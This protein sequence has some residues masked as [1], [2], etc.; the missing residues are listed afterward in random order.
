MLTRS[1]VVDDAP[2]LIQRR[3]SDFEK[4]YV[5]LKKQ[6]PHI[7]DQVA[8]PRKHFRGNFTPET[9]ARRSRSFEQI[10]GHLYLIDTIRFCNLFKEFF[11]A[12]DLKD[13]YGHL[14]E[15][16]YF[17][18]VSLFLKVIPAQ[19]RIMG[20]YSEDVGATLCSVTV[21]YRKL[22]EK[23]LALRYGLSGLKCLKN[24]KNI[25][26]YISLLS[27]CVHLS[28]V[29]GREKQTLETKLFEL[30]PKEKNIPDLF[31]VILEQK[32]GRTSP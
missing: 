23:E 1:G 19:E 10:L 11:Y 12:Q 31:D 15:G 32:Q 18:A 20:E 3:Y 8:F 28:W 17:K 21:C 27:S 6:Y 4:L 25:A 16:S 7:M 26:L 30:V 5:G 22:D 2:C 14:S 9:I 29:L 24:S 13:A